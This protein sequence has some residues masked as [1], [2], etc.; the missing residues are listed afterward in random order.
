MQLYELVVNLAD[1][2]DR[3]FVDGAIVI[4]GVIFLLICSIGWR[5]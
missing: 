3:D 1:Q 2:R 5:D 4:V